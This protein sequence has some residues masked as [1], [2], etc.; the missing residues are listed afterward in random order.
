MFSILDFREFDDV[1]VRCEMSCQ[2]LIARL[3]LDEHP[4]ASM[5]TD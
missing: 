1:G 3:A 4:D 5:T 2:P